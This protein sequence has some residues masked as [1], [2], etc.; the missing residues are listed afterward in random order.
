MDLPAD[1]DDMTF[2]KFVLPDRLNRLSGADRQPQNVDL[3]MKNTLNNTLGIQWNF[4]SDIN[5][6]S[7]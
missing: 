6:A 5:E 1:V 3:D 4:F 7:E 2:W